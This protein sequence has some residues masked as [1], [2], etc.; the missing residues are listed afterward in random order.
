MRAMLLACLLALTG[1]SSGFW[2][3]C[4]SIESKGFYWVSEAGF[5]G[6]GTIRYGR[7]TAQCKENP[8]P[9]P[10]ELPTVKGPPGTF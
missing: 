6:L 8:E 10:V 7:N 3:Q 5:M 2:R 9:A 4:V 1:C